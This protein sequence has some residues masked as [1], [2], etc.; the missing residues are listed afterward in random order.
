MGGGTGG[1]LGN[2][3]CNLKQ[4]LM[5]YIKTVGAL[6]VILLFLFTMLNIAKYCVCYLWDHKWSPIHS[7][8]FAIDYFPFFHLILI[9]NIISSVA[10][11]INKS[12]VCKH[13]SGCEDACC[14]RSALYGKQVGLT[15]PSLKV[16]VLVGSMGLSTQSGPA[17]MLAPNPLLCSP[18]PRGQSSDTLGL[19]CSNF[20][21][22][23]WSFCWD[24]GWGEHPHNLGTP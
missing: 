2:W 24:L 15:F 11:F 17:G 6:R 16:S 22:T 5:K 13:V 12:R 3:L 23:W 7:P 9:T 19:L 10:Q 21:L 1:C 8:T 4:I 20:T 18:L 14:R